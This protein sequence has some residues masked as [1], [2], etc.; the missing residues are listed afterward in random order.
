MVMNGDKKSRPVNGPL[1]RWIKDQRVLF[2]LVGGASTVFSTLL[3][4]L[5][6]LFFPRVPSSVSVFVAWAVALMAT[7]GVYRR[8]VFRVKGHFWLDL[9]RFASV[10][11]TTLLV[12]IGSMALLADVLA[13]PPIPVQIGITGVVVVFNYM[14]HKH[15]SFRRKPATPKKEPK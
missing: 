9:V 13:L 8:L 3:F 1:Q 5:L 14:G 10:N 6:V 15:F 12:N 2:V 7:F 4:V 11:T